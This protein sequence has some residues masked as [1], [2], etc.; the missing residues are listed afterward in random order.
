MD[1]NEILVKIYIGQN[2]RDE[3]VL[4]STFSMLTDEKKA[5]IRKELVRENQWYSHNLYLT[6][7]KGAEIARSLVNKRIEAKRKEIEDFLTTFPPR[8]VGFLVNDYLA[9]SLDFHE[10][11][12]GIFGIYGLTSGTVVL[13]QDFKIW[14]RRTEILSKLVEL[15]LSIKTNYYVS[16]RGE[17]RESRY[18]IPPEVRELLLEVT[19]SYGLTEEENRNCRIYDFLKEIANWLDRPV[20][21]EVRKRYVDQMQR[22]NIDEADIE[23]VI[24]KLTE[25]GI[26]DSYYGIGTP[27]V[28]P[29]NIKDKIS[30]LFHLQN[31]LIKPIVTDLLEGKPKK[32]PE[33]EEYEQ[34][35][36][37]QRVVGLVEAKY[38]LTQ[39]AGIFGIDLFDSTPD[40]EICITRMLKVPST[41]GELKEFI[42][43]LYNYIID[44]SKGWLLRIGDLKT[45]ETSTIEEKIIKKGKSIPP[46]SAAE[47]EKAIQDLRMLN[48]LR[49]KLSHSKAAKDW[50]DIANIYRKLINKP[51]PHGKEDYIKVQESLLDRVTQSLESLF[52]M[53]M[54]LNS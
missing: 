8:L 25:K 1:E 19:P 39:N 13:L 45:G 37:L 48:N 21:E 17:M 7:P 43:T 33:K 44:R 28:K 53:F 3:G 38:T 52:Q 54:K 26:T 11:M 24:V 36:V 2:I 27:N 47:F 15:G 31:L 30:Y 49:N 41:D 14:S 20:V 51:L 18:V 50:E 32:I 5:L 12:P 42:E 22:L 9:K 10:F 34:P 29:Y 46:E 23:A 40:T 35:Q 16:T 6:T 4:Q